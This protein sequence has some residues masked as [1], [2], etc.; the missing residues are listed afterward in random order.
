MMTQDD[1]T[2][3]VVG[4]TGTIGGAALRALL[5][6]GARVRALVRSPA[7]MQ[8]MKGVEIMAG[9]LADPDAVTRALQGIQVALYVS[10]HEQ[11]EEHLAET[12]ITQ[13][14]KQ[15]VRLVFVGVHVDAPTR[16]GRAV[17]RL[18]FGR[19]A[20]SYKAKFRISERARTSSTRPIVLMPTNFFDNDLIFSQELCRGQFIQ[21]FN[22][23]INRVAAR[24]VGEA[25]ARACL[26]PSLPSGAYP[27][28][29]PVSLDGPACAAVWSEA[30][31]AHVRYLVD[32]ALFRDAVMRSCSG[33]KVTDFLSSYQAIRNFKLP[34]SQSDLAR[35]TALLGRAPTP[36]AEYVREV[37]AEWR[38]PLA[39]RAS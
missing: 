13:C 1:S 3:L 31:G 4:A 17:R 33:K 22:H 19:M 21:P 38:A 5:S 35:T 12:F 34:T 18:L 24:D 14:E 26:D 15:A 10:P 16:L 32:D 28:V 29:G 7:R 11:S 27:V 6:Q 37:V 25:A 8:G 30:L 20:P 2:I 36:Y 39:A 9:D 23:P